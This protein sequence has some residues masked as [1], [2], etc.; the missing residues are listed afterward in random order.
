VDEL[1]VD[2]PHRRY[3]N[4]RSCF[5]SIFDSLLGILTVGMAFPIMFLLPPVPEK[6]TRFFSI[7]EKEIAVLRSREA[8]NEPDAHFRAKHLLLVAKDLKI[9]FFGMYIHFQ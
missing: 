3:A 9:W 1:E 7:E 5:E 6:I 4:E 8:F 2:L